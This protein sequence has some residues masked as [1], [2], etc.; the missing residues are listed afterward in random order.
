MGSATYLEPR[1]RIPRCVLECRLWG[2]VNR[3]MCSS[4]SLPPSLPPSLL[5]SLPTVVYSR[6][7]LPAT[8]PGLAIPGKVIFEI[9][10]LA[11]YRIISRAT[12]VS[13]N[14]TGRRRR[15]EFMCG[16]LLC[17]LVLRII[18]YRI[19]NN[20]TESNRK[21]RVNGGCAIDNSL[22]LFIKFNDGENEKKRMQKVDMIR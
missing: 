19:V 13:P 5:P 17:L 22:V 7:M 8:V 11:T 6:C 16:H 10:P 12:I 9:A 2:T 20:R 15:R 3:I 21:K 14:K 18:L 4:P 1:I